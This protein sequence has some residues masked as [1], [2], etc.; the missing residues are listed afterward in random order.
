MWRKQFKKFATTNIDH[1]CHMP[2]INTLHVWGKFLGP[3]SIFPF[4]LYD[5]SAFLHYF[6]WGGALIYF[7]NSIEKLLD[8]FVVVACDVCLG[9]SGRGIDRNVSSALGLCEGVG[10]FFF[11]WVDRCR[12]GRSPGGTGKIISVMSLCCLGDVNAELLFFPGEGR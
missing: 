6:F 10:N 8:L 7:K 2:T 9:G 4:Y 3:T 12:S 11:L 5:I 1:I